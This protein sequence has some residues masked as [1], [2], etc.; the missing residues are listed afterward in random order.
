MMIGPEYLREPE[1]GTHTEGRRVHKKTNTVYGKGT[2]GHEV[3]TQPP[4]SELQI[5][6]SVPDL[7]KDG[8]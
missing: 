7:K 2:R 4:N 8:G 3:Q 5:T 6:Y 1:G